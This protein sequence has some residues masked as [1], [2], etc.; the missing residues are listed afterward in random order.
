MFDNFLTENFSRYLQPMVV[1]SMLRNFSS[2]GAPH[3]KRS[4]VYFEAE[5]GRTYSNMQY[6]LSGMANNAEAE[7][8]RGGGVPGMRKLDGP[9]MK[10]SGRVVHRARRKCGSG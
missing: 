4:A 9:I 6:T 5:T 2:I 3:R 7:R 8:D 1:A 10:S